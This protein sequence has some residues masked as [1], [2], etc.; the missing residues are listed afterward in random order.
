MIVILPERRQ[1]QAEDSWCC[2]DLSCDYCQG[3]ETD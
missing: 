2:E 3:P 1:E